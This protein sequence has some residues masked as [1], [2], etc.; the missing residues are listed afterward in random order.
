MYRPQYAKDFEE[1][2]IQSWPV[3]VLPKKDGGRCMIDMDATGWAKPRGKRPLVQHKD[4]IQKMIQKVIT[5]ESMELVMPL[6]G[7]LFNDCD[8]TQVVTKK[9]A[10]DDPRLTVGEMHTAP[11]HF[12]DIC[13]GIKGSKSVYHQYLQ[14]HLFDIMNP[15][16]PF[17]DRYAHLSW[18]H[19]RQCLLVPGFSDFVKLVPCKLAHN[20]EELTAL[21]DAWSVT[22][23]GVI[24]RDPNEHYVYDKRTRGCMRW[25]Y[26]KDAE[27][28]VYDMLEG[29]GKN[30]GIPTFYCWDPKLGGPDDKIAQFKAASAGEESFRRRLWRERDMIIRQKEVTITFQNL[31][32]RGVPRFGSVKAVRDYE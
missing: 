19:A 21:M 26:F 23:E 3:M 8:V 24:I 20:M 7:E 32:K 6:D 17:K 29:V 4:H 16:K 13:S 1:Q 12:E 5:P 30:V 31:T 14:Y 10:K 18:W 27:Y 22:D 28:P 15:D 25:K 2:F 11:M 9:M